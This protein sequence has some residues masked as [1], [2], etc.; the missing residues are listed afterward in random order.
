MICATFPLFFFLIV[1]CF[2]FYLLKVVPK[3]YV[4]I[5]ESSFKLCPMKTIFLHS[6]LTQFIMLLFLWLIWLEP[7]TLNP[8]YFTTWNKDNDWVIG[9]KPKI[10]VAKGNREHRKNGNTV[11]LDQKAEGKIQ[12]TWF[13]F[14]E[15]S[16]F[17]ELLLSIHNQL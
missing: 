3:S 15:Q 17:K 6:T 2:L 1:A 12:E 16:F 8:S 13:L 7:E 9:G 14:V 11:L 4:I 5:L 10:E